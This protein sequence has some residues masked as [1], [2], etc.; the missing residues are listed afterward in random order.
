MHPPTHP[1]LFAGAQVRCAHVTLGGEVPAGLHGGG[2]LGIT[3]QRATTAGVEL[4][5]EESSPVMQFYSWSGMHK[6][7]GGSKEWGHSRRCWRQGG[8]GTQQPVLALSRLHAYHAA[9]TSTKC[10]PGLCVQ[11]PR[12]SCCSSREW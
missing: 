3:Y 10:G 2:L 9:S 4:S 8:V 6:V 11:A 7:C 1:T 5:G 12:S